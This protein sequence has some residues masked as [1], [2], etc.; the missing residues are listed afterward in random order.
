MYFLERQRPSQMKKAGY[1]KI[2]IT[3]LIYF[4]LFFYIYLPERKILWKTKNEKNFS[5]TLTNRFSLVIW[6]DW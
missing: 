1:M 6:K 2:F 5:N 4:Q 3:P